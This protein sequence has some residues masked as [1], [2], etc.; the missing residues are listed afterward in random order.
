MVLWGRELAFPW[1]S[2]VLPVAQLSPRVVC[3]AASTSQPGDQACVA[4]PGSALTLT[5]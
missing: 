2:S 1:G 3:P 5:A 4:Q